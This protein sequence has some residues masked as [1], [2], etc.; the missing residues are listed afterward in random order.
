MYFEVERKTRRLR[1]FM[2]LCSPQFQKGSECLFC[3]QDRSSK[4]LG[5]F[6][7]YNFV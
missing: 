1:F 4:R 2:A 6:T 7:G 3:R 5:R